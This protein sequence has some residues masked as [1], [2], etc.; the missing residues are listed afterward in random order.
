MYQKLHENEY[1][2]FLAVQLSKRNESVS[3]RSMRADGIEP[4]AIVAYLAQ[5][6][7]ATGAS[8]CTAGASCGRMKLPA[9][10]SQEESV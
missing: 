4:A 1:F 3:L 5:S 6:R 9:M 8:W 7:E 2:R 10:L